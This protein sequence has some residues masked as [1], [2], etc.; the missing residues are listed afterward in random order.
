MTIII[1]RARI[2]ELESYGTT[3]LEYSSYLDAQA[4]ILVTVSRGILCVI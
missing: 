4:V 1:E 3:E 2:S